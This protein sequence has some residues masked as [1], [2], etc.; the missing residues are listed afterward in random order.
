[1]K[2]R[3]RLWSLLFASLIALGS[4]SA[5]A[6]DADETPEEGAVEQ[7]AAAEEEEAEEEAAEE[8]AAE[9]EAA[10]EE[11]AEEEEPA[12]EEAAEEE[13]AEEE[14]AEEEEEP[15][16]SAHGS[17]E[18]KPSWGG[19][20]EAGV[21]FNSLDRWNRNL[22]D[23][24]E[25]VFDTSTIWHF[26]GAVE[27]SFIEGTRLTF[28]GGISSPFTDNPSLSAWYL[29]LEPAFAFRRDRWEM[30]I[31]LG[32]GIG[33]I[34]VSVDPDMSADTALVVLRPFL[35]VRRYLS[36]SAAVYVRGGFNQWLP[37]NVST[38]GLP[39]QEDV[40]SNTDQE[41][42]EGGAYL[43]LGVRFGSY[44]E[45]VKVVPDTDG[46]GF[47]D[48]VDSCPEEPED[49]DGFEDE[50]GCPDL[51]NDQDGIVDAQDEC[52]DKA[53][54]MDG[55]E[56]EDGCPET[57][58]DTDGDGILDKDDKCPDEPED[59]DG[60]EDKDGCPEL[61]NDQDGI[62][63]AED[64]CPNQKGVAQK[65]GCPLKRVVVTLKQIMINEK[66]FFEYDKAAIK[67]Q[68]HDLL[69]EVAQVLK[70][71]PRIKQ[72]E[73]QGHTDHKGSQDYNTELSQKRAQAVHDY[74][75]AQGVAEDRLTAKGYGFS[76]PLVKLEEGEEESEEAAA[77]NRRVE[78]VIR[79]QDDVK[80]VMSEDE[81]PEDAAEV[82]ETDETVPVDGDA[83][84]AE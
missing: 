27:A 72:I 33:G 3:M 71:N 68:S 24:Q 41:L 39:F 70:D 35:E 67:E 73:I 49:V 84:D 23:D 22:L 14:A 50:D 20:V 78:F 29:G 83:E 10:E 15:A 48:D 76:E 5:L 16:E 74:L 37:F 46:D 61:D 54:D 9:E 32:A 12:E 65:N 1:M 6:Q 60:F 62:V 28:F 47:R 45:H 40:N 11:A 19:G 64:E 17:Y 79:E 82:E 25:P 81:V 44:P 42:D 2:T 56:D 43:A 8:E 13:A 55:W 77:K 69:N 80:K 7:E 30:G 38:E 66:V 26:D 51:D 4:Q 57:N 53:E 34:D 36:E 63:D 75:V 59:F 31:G 21:F 18:W 52:P 58:D